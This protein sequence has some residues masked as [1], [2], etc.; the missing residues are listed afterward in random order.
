M[1]ESLECLRIPTATAPII[2]PSACVAQTLDAFEHIEDS[3]LQAKWMLGYLNWNDSEIPLISFDALLNA[4][5]TAPDTTP[6]AV[7]LNPIPKSPRKSFGSLIC[8]GEIEPLNVDLSVVMAELPAS[9]DRRYCEAAIGFNG[10][11][12]I[13]PKLAALGVALSYF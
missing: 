1:T 2:L 5:F 9:I 11:V 10:E 6:S 7:V 8:Y 12:L 13:V 4:D 3:R